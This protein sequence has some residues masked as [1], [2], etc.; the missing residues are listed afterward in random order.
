MFSAFRKTRVEE[1]GN[2][3][4]ILKRDEIIAACV[5]CFLISLNTFLPIYQIHL[6]E[7]RWGWCEEDKAKRSP[8]KAI[9]SA[10]NM[11]NVNAELPTTQKMKFS[12][13]DFF[14]KCEL[15]LSFLRIWSHLLK[16]S[17]KENFIFYAVRFIADE[18]SHSLQFLFMPRLLLSQL[19]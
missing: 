2:Y 12:I 1:E 4:Y 18:K 9:H 19:P 7:Q 5:T 16:K 8:K 3:V 14:S 13:K 11:W 17:L 6:Q 15:I 10:M